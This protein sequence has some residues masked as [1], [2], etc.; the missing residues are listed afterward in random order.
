LEHNSRVAAPHAHHFTDIEQQREAGTLGMWAFLITEIMFFG[1]VF[2]AYALYRSMYPEA[3]GA[4]SLRLNIVLGAVNTAVLICSS[5]TM[6]LAVQSA[7][8]GRQ[9][10][11][12]RYLIA[13]IILGSAFLV[14]KAFEYSHKI[15]ENLVPG[16]SFFFAG[17]HGEQAEIFFS[18]YFVMTGLHAVHMI[19][20]IGIMLVLL[21]M[22]R[23]GRF[24]EDYYAPVDIAGLYW[25]FVDLVWIYLFPL[26]YLISRD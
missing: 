20:G 11:L 7:Q 9:K 17:P 22:A 4:A 19:I 12:V 26:L 13:T 25:H 21:V 23:R 16:K 10:A 1:G 18:L 24:T 8:N 6:V 5:L 3:F 2:V 14:I 15:H